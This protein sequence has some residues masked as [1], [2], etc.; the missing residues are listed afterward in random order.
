MQRLIFFLFLLSVL[1]FS[2][3]VSHRQIVTFNDVDF[4]LNTPE[5]I[6]NQV[7]LRIQPDDVLNIQVS[8]FDP[9]AAAPFNLG[10]GQRNNNQMMNNQNLGALSL[11]QGYLVGPNGVIDFPVLGPVEVGGLTLEELRQ[12]LLTQLEPYLKDAAVN[13]RYLNFRV[14]L[15]GEVGRPSTYNITNNRISIFDAI[16]MAGDLTD[17]ANRTN[18]LVIREQNGQREYGRLDLQSIDCF[19]SPYFYLKQN[20]V[21]YV[22]PLPSRTATV[23]DPIQRVISYV[24]AGLSIIT[25]ILALSTR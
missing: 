12:E 1:T 14:T 17:Y 15:L 20:D 5:E 13:I 10:S 2:S 22:E 18:V 23:A 21:V 16:G 6:A 7:E 8:S 11:F 25:I 19:Q 3:C 4:P 24:S 9:Q